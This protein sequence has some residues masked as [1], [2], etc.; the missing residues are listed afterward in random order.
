M[1]PGGWTLE[2]AETVCGAGLEQ[3]SLV[4]K[5]LLRQTDGRFWML[6]TI[7]EYAAGRLEA[8][9]HA[10][11]TPAAAVEVAAGTAPSRANF[12]P[13]RREARA[14]WTSSRPSCRTSTPR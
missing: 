2:A 11:M 5:S 10:E 13:E 7:R 8:S 14:S 12:Q 3:Q 9:G 4:E 1:F 6:E